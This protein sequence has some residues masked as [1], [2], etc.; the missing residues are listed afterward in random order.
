MQMIPAISALGRPSV[1]PAVRSICWSANAIF[2]E[3]STAPVSMQGHIN[4]LFLSCSTLC[5]STIDLERSM[6]ERGEK[7]K[8]LDSELKKA[9]E[10]HRR[11][12]KRKEAHKELK[13]LEG[14]S[15][16]TRK[17]LLGSLWEMAT[18]IGRGYKLEDIKSLVLSSV[19]KERGVLHL[20]DIEAFRLAERQATL[21]ELQDK[22]FTLE[23][24]CA[25]RYQVIFIYICYN[26]T[27][28]V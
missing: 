14:T 3:V 20:A 24:S 25:L 4:R 12:L 6:L 9:Q 15:L 8:K 17:Q 11:H 2:K 7:I 26:S 28:N 1:L 16:N 27:P 5:E 18:T 13:P 23:A 21:K 19:A 22:V 10:Q